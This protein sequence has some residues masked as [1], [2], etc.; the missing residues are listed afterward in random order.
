MPTQ[1]K[2]PAAADGLINNIDNFDQLARDIATPPTGAPIRDAIGASGRL[3]CDAVGSDPGQFLAPFLPGALSAPLLCKPYWDSQGYDAPVKAVPFFGGQCAGSEYRP[4]GTYVNTNAAAGPTGP[5]TWRLNVTVVGPISGFVASGSPTGTSWGFLSASNGGAPFGNAIDV[6][7]GKP[8]FGPNDTSDSG[9]MRSAG[10]PSIT[11]VGLQFGPDNCGDPDEVL[12]PGANP[13][14]SPTFGP[15][16][17]PGG[18]PGSQPFFTIPDI[19]NPITGEP[20]IPVPPSPQPGLPGPSGPPPGG[21]DPG[22]GGTATPGD[23]A[24]D[25]APTGKMLWGL[26]VTVDAAPENARQYAPGVYRAV[27]YIYMGDD[28]GLDHDPA[29]AMLR[30]GQ[31]VLAER[32]YLTKWRVTANPGYTLSVIP[33]YKDI[34]ATP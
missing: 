34:E 29:G 32:D 33:Y 8:V 16:E 13:P 10:A 12:Q 28:D 20:G 24:E 5:R 26:R 1:Y 23:D 3:Y 27:G 25:E 15:G 21:G 17:G 9:V 11:D 6:G 2:L 30:S 4:E 22:D 31:F 14:P 19:P 7:N 18:G